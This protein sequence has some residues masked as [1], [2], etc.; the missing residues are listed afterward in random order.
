MTINKL[1]YQEIG[2]VVGFLNDNFSIEPG[3]QLIRGASQSNAP[4]GDKERR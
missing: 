3:L 4:L 2:K 1:N